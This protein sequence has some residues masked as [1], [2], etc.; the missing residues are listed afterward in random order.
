MTP[1]GYGPL[2]HNVLALQRQPA[3]LAGAQAL[4]VEDALELGVGE[5]NER[6]PFVPA[7]KAVLR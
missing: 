3:L 7:R 5:R 1:K 2:V 6:E 4:L